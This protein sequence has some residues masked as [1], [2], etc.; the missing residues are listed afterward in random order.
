M[1]GFLIWESIGRSKNYKEFLMKRFWRIYP[2]LWVAVVLEIGVLLLLYDYPVDLKQMIAFCLG[3]LTL[4]QFWTPDC[5]RDYGC[6]CPN[7]ALW[8]IC[9]IIQFYIISYFIYKLFHGRSVWV[10]GFSILL[11]ILLSMAQECVESFFGDSVGKLYDVTICRYLWMFHIASFVAEF[12][13]RI[14]L[15]LKKYWLVAI[16]ILLMIKYF[17]VDIDAGYKLFNT[18]L[19]FLGLTGAAYALPQLNINRDISYGIY[20]YHMTIVNAMLEMGYLH[21]QWLLVL[22]VLITIVVAWC[23]MVTVG[24]WGLSHKKINI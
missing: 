7:G 2:E 19:L 15:Y 23:S 24:T 20:I 5:L 10:W 14:I 16:I 11:T 17:H 4:F 18:T 9:V 22:V 12:K 13:E 6:G 1:S 8:T 21:H 3:Q